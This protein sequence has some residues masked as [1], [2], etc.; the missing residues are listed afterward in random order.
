[1]ADGDQGA[2]APKKGF[3]LWIILAGGGAVAL[4][5]YLR[6]RSSTSAQTAQP[7][8]PAVVTDP[9]TGLPIDPLTGL[10]FQGTSTQPQTMT[11]WIGKAEAWALGKHLNSG[12]VNKA[13]F[14]YTNG[15]R[16][17]PREAAIIDQILS[18]V[19]YPPDLLPFKGP[20]LDNPTKPKG[21]FFNW[22]TWKWFG[23]QAG[24][25]Y[26]TE[27]KFLPKGSHLLS[28][29]G[30]VGSN[31]IMPLANAPIYALVPRNW[32]AGTHD[33]TG[34][35]TWRRIDNNL[36]FAA[37]PKGTQVS[38]FSAYAPAAA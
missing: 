20:G 38:T 35:L 2:A 24:E 19:G 11:D 6:R 12:L 9:N 30:K 17:G 4:F 31:I 15:N 23:L 36:A 29:L 27:P 32:T 21:P 26:A 25:S 22:Q 37:L 7:L 34:P 28:I 3:P 33:M 1:M 5:L 14:D 18:A 8:V 10:P 13:L 16:L